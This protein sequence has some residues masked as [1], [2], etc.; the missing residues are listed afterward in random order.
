VTDQGESGLPGSE[1]VLGFGSEES[2]PTVEGESGGPGVVEPG[3]LEVDM[4]ASLDVDE[5]AMAEAGKTALN[6]DGFETGAGFDLESSPEV[7][8]QDF[9]IEAMEVRSSSFDEVDAQQAEAAG[10]APQNVED[11]A[12]NELLIPSDDDEAS[13]LLPTPAADQEPEVRHGALEALARQ[14]KR[15]A[16]ARLLKTASIVVL[17]G[18]GTFAVG[19]LG[20]VEIPGITPSERSRVFVAAPAP[21]PG[22]QPETAVMSHVIFIDTWR[23]AETPG[24]WA[25]ALRERMP[26]LLGLVTPLSIDGDRQF[27]LL[28]G[29]AYNAA[30]AD[31]LR[32]PLAEAF[33]LLN[34]DPDSWVVQEA[35]YS[36]FLGEYE[37]QGEANSRVQALAGLAVP[38]FVLRVTYPEQAGAFRVYA[39]AFSDELE[40]RGMARL[41]NENDLDDAAFTELRGRLPG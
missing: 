34:P 36:F 26:N 17:L 18:G 4:G 24:A 6:M 14:R 9:E 23:E 12:V 40:A 22:P 10:A 25:D 27:A 35:P 37:T 5:D 38:A 21:L 2:E 11:P 16:G 20:L 8:G 30:E 13:L 1:D 3:P 7:A 32:A 41:L 19:Y 29:P 33:D 39:G 15:R 31:R 28:V